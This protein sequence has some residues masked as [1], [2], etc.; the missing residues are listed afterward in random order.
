[1]ES[2]III[3]DATPADAELIAWTVAE[4]SD[5][6]HA[7]FDRLKSIASETDNL[8]SWQNTRV[9]EVDGRAVGCQI[10]FTGKHYASFRKRT[11]LAVWSPPL[12][13]E[14]IDR[15]P[16]EADADE[17]HLDSIAILPEY[18]G[19]GISRALIMDSVRRGQAL[20]YAHIAFLV[21]TDKPSLHD[22]Y[23]RLGFV[24]EK[25]VRLFLTDYIKMRYEGF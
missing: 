9:A 1:M 3:R 13:E 8:F 23:A 20:G 17:Y 10:T 15:A 14:I 7:Y 24:D 18:Q 4:A 2:S 19:R 5:G 22:Y 25:P 21:E 12:T 16:L 6:N 11:W